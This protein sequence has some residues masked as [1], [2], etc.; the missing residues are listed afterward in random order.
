MHAL[1]QG[2]CK[3]KSP[4]CQKK[5]KVHLRHGDSLRRKKD[6][7]EIERQRLEAAERMKQ[8]LGESWWR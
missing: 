7:D 8:E 6:N 2:T 1:I 4:A 5:L 3:D